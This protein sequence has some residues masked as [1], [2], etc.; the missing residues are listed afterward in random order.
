[1]KHRLLQVGGILTFEITSPL[2]E[3][4]K[5][6]RSRY[7]EELKENERKEASKNKEKEI[8]NNNSIEDI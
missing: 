5:L 4:I 8:Q 1:V 2:I 6:S 3:S 7:E